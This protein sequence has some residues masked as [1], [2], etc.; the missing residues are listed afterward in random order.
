MTGHELSQEG[1][2]MAPILF[3]VE[4]EH[5]AARVRLAKRVRSLLNSTDPAR[6]NVGFFLFGVAEALAGA[7]AGHVRKEF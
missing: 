5:A 1:A 2:A 4:A 3:P 7:R 6:R